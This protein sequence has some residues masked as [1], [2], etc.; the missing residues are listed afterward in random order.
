VKEDK[1]V[2]WAI[3][4]FSLIVFA[5]VVILHELPKAENMPSWML[6]APKFNAILNGSC[7]VL[8]ISSLLAVK[9]KNIALHRK[10]N[11]LAMLLSVTFLFSYVLFHYFSGDTIYGGDYKTAYYIILISHV[12]LAG[13]S[14]PFILLAYYRGHIGAIDKHKRMVRYIYPVWLYVCITGVIVY[15]FLAP[16]YSF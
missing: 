2:V 4:I 3:W 13:L 15:L 5:V 7:G 16:Y 9:R 11:T 12:L 14:L 8:L 1:R 6:Q 10:L